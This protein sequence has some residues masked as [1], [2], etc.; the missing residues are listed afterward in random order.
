MVINCSNLGQTD[1]PELQLDLSKL[2]T[3][4]T[5]CDIVYRPLITPLLAEAQKRGNAIVEGLG[6]L[7]HQGRLGF[8]YWFGR[9]PEV[10]VELY[11]YMGELAK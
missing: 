6:M 11:K 9:D 7:L 4:A 1:N 2:P 5:V 3:T 8:G 10:S